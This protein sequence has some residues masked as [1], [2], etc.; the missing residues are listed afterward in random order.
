M[1]LYVYVCTN[2]RLPCSPYI[3]VPK[4]FCSY[5]NKFV[6]QEFKKKCPF[7]KNYKTLRAFIAQSSANE[8]Q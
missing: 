6:F 1:K 3:M 7:I 2:V 5:H 4:L 8:L